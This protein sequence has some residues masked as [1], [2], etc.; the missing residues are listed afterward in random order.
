MKRIY[1]AV[2][3]GF[4]A[5]LNGLFSQTLAQDLKSAFPV[6]GY[7]ETASKINDLVHTRLDVR[8]D[9]KKRYLYG[10]EW[11]TLKPHF[12]PTD[13][14]RLDAKGMD[15]RTIA[16]S[17]NGKNIPLHFSYDSLSLNIRL[18]KI[19][20]PAENY[21]LYIDYTSKPEE[22]K[23]RRNNEHGLYFINPDGAEKDKPTQ[24][25]TLGEPENNSCWFPTIDKPNQKTTQEISMTVP[26]KYV[27][28]SNGRLESQKNNPDGTR[29]D[30]WK[31]ELPHSPYLF[32]MAVGDFKIIKDSW[33]GKQVSYYLEPK[34]APYA[35]DNFGVVPEAIDFFSKTLG[36]DF[37]W[38]KYAEVSVRDY[39]GGAMENTTAAIFGNVSTRRELADSYYNPGIEHEL[40][41]QWFGDYVTCESWSNITLN[42]SFADFGELIWLEHKYGKDAADGH[43]QYGL[44]NYLDS[45]DARA[46]NLVTF[47]Y[48]NPKDPFGITYS[49]GGRVLNMLRNYLGDVAFYKG[50]HLYLT[51]YAFK[52]AEVPQLR[53]ALEEASGLD[54]NWFFNQWYYGAGH[55][56]LDIRY[57]WDEAAKTQKIFVHQTQDGTAFTLPV[58]V[59]VYTGGVK[60]RHR[61]WLRNHS[62][63]LTF[64]MPSKPDLVNV[65]A[66][67]ILVAEKT[68]H[69]TP[70]ELVYQYFHAPLYLDRYE[71]MDFAEKNTDDLQAQRVLIAALKDPFSGLRRKAI[72]A[73]NQNKEDIQ[74]IN[75]DLRNAALPLLA[76]IARTDPNTL[77]QA[78]AINTLSVLK[79]P[80]YLE[81]FKQGLNSPSYSVS[82]SALNAISHID[83]TLGFSLAKR[84]ENDNERELTQAIISVYAER[85]DDT[86]WPFV[87][88]RYK[89]AGFQDQVHLTKA[90]SG[91]V[92]RLTRQEAVLQGIGELKQL[93]IRYKGDGAAPFMIR[94]LNIIKDQRTGLNDPA[95]A[96][97]ARAAIQQINDAN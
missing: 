64:K 84:F 88:Q 20:Q 65:D 82:G 45:H 40:F 68:D 95:G 78:D 39:V 37:P 91:M 85:G 24:I 25:W 29:T 71:A 46:K 72:Q 53:M 2:A 26:R 58:A 8:F 43:L 7:R 61:V 28:L 90:F 44:Q 16:I 34:Y 32:M 81:L 4:I 70:T 60:E 96:K 66:D 67:K 18:D 33:H 86:Q 23:G 1:L 5:L 62:D 74:N 15:I 42:E 83:P 97:V 80:A 56:V 30:T 31:M 36:V 77:V 50:L 54:L 93:A 47:Y 51:T 73:L 57:L 27:S 92:G 55:P 59:D 12:Y 69:K 89:A 9:Y 79:D 17:K 10:E 49:K 52:N 6:K 21:T 3:I 38:N 13:T 14:L 19:Y 11:V 87:Y 75:T 48:T 35:K 22:L 94:F 76:N 41:H 63:T